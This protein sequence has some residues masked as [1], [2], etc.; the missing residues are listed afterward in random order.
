MKAPPIRL[1][2]RA[3]LDYGRR[4]RPGGHLAETID[5]SSA[6]A[7]DKPQRWCARFIG[8]LDAATRAQAIPPVDQAVLYRM[9]Q[10]IIGTS[11][12][13][14]IQWVS[15][16]C[17]DRDPSRT[18]AAICAARARGLSVAEIARRLDVSRGYLYN[19][20]EGYYQPPVDPASSVRQNIYRL[21]DDTPEAPPL[22]SG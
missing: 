19:L 10:Y 1:E 11:D 22:F 2:Y 13:Y 21:A 8:L 18:A 20:I 16:L 12:I 5:L 17:L 15:Q 4:Q 6:A 7:D 3:A 9:T 14:R